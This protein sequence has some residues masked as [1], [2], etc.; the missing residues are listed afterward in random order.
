MLL[1]RCIKQ[2]LL[3]CVLVLSCALPAHAR[4]ETLTEF[5]PEDAIA[6][7]L[8]QTLRSL[9]LLSNEKPVNLVALLTFYR[10]RDFQPAW[11]SAGGLSS[12]RALESGSSRSTDARVAA[13]SS[14]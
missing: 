1:T 8:E 5:Y 7:E 12:G 3:V 4:V 11:F 2:G 6:A 9:T 14:P 13:T 10:G